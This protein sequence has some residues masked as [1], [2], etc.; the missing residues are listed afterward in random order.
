MFCAAIFS[1]LSIVDVIS[2]LNECRNENIFLTVTIRELEQKYSFRFQF[3][4]IFIF[5]RSWWLSSELHLITVF[6][7]VGGGGGDVWL[8][9]RVPL[10]LQSLSSPIKLIVRGLRKFYL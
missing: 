2:G 4:F 8:L 7:V 3:I 5:I 1:V 10:F 9:C 6:V